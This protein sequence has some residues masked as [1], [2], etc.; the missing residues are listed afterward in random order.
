M[1]IHADHE[2][3]HRPPD[4]E[5]PQHDEHTY[6]NTYWGR[7]HIDCIHGAVTD[8]GHPICFNLSRRGA[9]HRV[10]KETMVW[11][12]YRQARYGMEN[13]IVGPITAK[14]THEPQRYINKS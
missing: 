12:L 10:V 2:T 5:E 14:V 3:L 9:G 13:P 11:P 7:A 8:D 1:S 4:A 6:I